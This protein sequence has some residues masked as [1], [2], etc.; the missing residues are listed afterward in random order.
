MDRFDG[1]TIIDG[2]NG[3]INM[4]GLDG[5]V[6]SNINGFNGFINMDGLDGLV[7]GN[8]NGSELFHATNVLNADGVF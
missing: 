1:L 7:S 2:C 8:I 5:L 3:S 4:D 6:S